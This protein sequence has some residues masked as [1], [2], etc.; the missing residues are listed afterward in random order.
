MALVLGRSMHWKG[1]PLCLAES[2]PLLVEAYEAL[3]RKALA[4][5]TRAHYAAR[6]APT[7]DVFTD[8]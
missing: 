2:G 3:G 8:D 5:I 4:G 1:G 6:D 7:V